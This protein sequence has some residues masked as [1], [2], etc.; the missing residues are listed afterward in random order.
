MDRTPTSNNN[1]QFLD[2]YMKNSSDK[3][4]SLDENINKSQSDNSINEKY[5]ETNKKLD[6]GE[7]LDESKDENSFQNIK[8]SN[9]D[10]KP[11]LNHFINSSVY[12]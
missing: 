7:S 4:E 11:K 1:S 12:I 10:T 3:K 9:E 5:N 2:N 6:F 8:K